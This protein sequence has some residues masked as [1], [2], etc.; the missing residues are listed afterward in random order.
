M[1]PLCMGYGFGRRD[2]LMMQMLSEYFGCMSHASIL[3]AG[4]FRPII[5]EIIVTH[6]FAPNWNA[7]GIDK[8]GSTFIKL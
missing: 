5:Q 8:S 3:G 4:P 2:G 6:V 7:D 1:D